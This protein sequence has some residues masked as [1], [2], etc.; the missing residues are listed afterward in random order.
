MN[1]QM[2]QIVQAEPLLVAVQVR[3]AVN[4]QVEAALLAERMR[5]WGN[6]T[7]VCEDVLRF[8]WAGVPGA[9]VVGIPARVMERTTNKRV[10]R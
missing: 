8:S 1:Y 7:V 5:P 10:K 3:V 6:V 2:M 9:T 4:K